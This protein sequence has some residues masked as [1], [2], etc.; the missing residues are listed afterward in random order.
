MSLHRAK[1]RAQPR[2][3]TGA[4]IGQVGALQEPTGQCTRQ[5]PTVNACVVHQEPHAQIFLGLALTCGGLPKLVAHEVTEHVESA[6]KKAMDEQ[7]TQR[8]LR[9]EAA[10]EK[11]LEPLKASLAT[12][13]SEQAAALTSLA[14]RLEHEAQ[15]AH[16]QLLA[17][18]ANASTSVA[19]AAPAAAVHAAVAHE[20]AAEK[21]APHAA[22]TGEHAHAPA[23]AEGVAP[24]P[25]SSSAPVEA[26]LSHHAPADEHAVPEHSAHP[27]GAAHEP[28]TGHAEH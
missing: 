9:M 21:P 24:A 28:H 19:A 23:D 26:H 16:A 18:L 1:A 2:H 3:R 12:L 20:H 10:Q 11:Q 6:Q 5:I 25:V 7:E 17:A 15:K 4:P 22:A 27:T 14:H 8:T 13:K